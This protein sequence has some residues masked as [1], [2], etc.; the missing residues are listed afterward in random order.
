M[1]ILHLEELLFR[2]DMCNSHSTI[3]IKPEQVEAV[4]RVYCLLHQDIGT[5]HGRGLCRVAG[6]NDHDLKYIFKI[7]FGTTIYQL[8]LDLRM[9]SAA[10]QLCEGDQSIIS[11]AR[12]C[13]YPVADYFTILFKKC[14]GMSPTQYKRTMR[15]DFN[16]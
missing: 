6:M 1:K 13:G 8:L 4:H 15:V 3:K 10:K 7:V 5:N 16:L 14:F 12:S 11:I 2:L 9:Q